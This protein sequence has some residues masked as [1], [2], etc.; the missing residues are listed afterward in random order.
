M[1]PYWTSPDGSQV[2]CGDTLVVLNH[3]RSQ[4]RRFGC[5]IMDPP[6]AS[7]SRTE[8]SKPGSGAM[9]RGQ[10]WADRPIDCDQMTTTGFIW[11]VHR[12]AAVAQPRWSARIL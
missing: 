3:L 6:F 10:R 1:T 2:W 11:L 4:G 9:V 5:V 8:A 7:G 12:L